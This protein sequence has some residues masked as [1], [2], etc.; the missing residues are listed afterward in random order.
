[1]EDARSNSRKERMGPGLH[2]K[3]YIA[4][5]FI[6]KLAARLESKFPVKPEAWKWEGQKFNKIGFGGQKT[7]FIKEMLKEKRYSTEILGCWGR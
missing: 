1:M 4:N 5:D 7:T 3:N 2:L 6:P